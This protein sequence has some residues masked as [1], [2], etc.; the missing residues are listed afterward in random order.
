[1]SRRYSGRELWD[2]M[3]EFV[4]TP[5]GEPVFECHPWTLQKLYHLARYLATTTIA[6]VGNPNWDSVNYI[7]LFAGSGVCRMKHQT[8][9]KRFPGSA[10]M[11]AGCTKAFDNL[12]L[13][14]AERANIDA[15]NTR[16]QRLKCPSR[17]W[18][19]SGDANSIVAEIVEAIPKRR[20][21]N[22]LFVDP[23]ALEIHFK[24]I[25]YLARERPMDLIMLFADAYDIV[26]NVEKYY[27]PREDSRLDHFLGEAS[28]WRA[29]WDALSN[30]EGGKVRE[31]FASIYLERLRAIGYTHTGMRVIESDRGP[32]YRM[33]Y[34]SKHDR[35]LKFWNI[36]TSEDLGGARNLWS[37]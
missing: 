13:V 19:W 14:D 33:V 16:L 15:L 1:M 23:C 5:D 30:R 34:A 27:Y 26:R 17:V 2:R 11:A 6:M 20:A 4:A 25:D 3:C 9:G 12:Y 37:P 21:L 18:L 32:I 24:T 36:A 8:E 22:I 29:R 7:D 10:L 31:L 35:G 28:E